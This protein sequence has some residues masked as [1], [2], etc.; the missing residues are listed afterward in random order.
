VLARLTYADGMQ[1]RVA[2][3]DN[4]MKCSLHFEQGRTPQKEKI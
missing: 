2:F 1:R 3:E 4:P